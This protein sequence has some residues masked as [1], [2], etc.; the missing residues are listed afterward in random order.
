MPVLLAIGTGKG[1]FLARSEDERKSWEVSGPHFPMT[2]VYAVAIDKRRSVPRL[3]AGVT[4]PHFGPSVATSDD[5]G[6]SWREPERAPLAFPDDTGAALERV[7]Q[8][9]PGPASQPD[10]VYAGVEPSA[11]FVSDDGGCTYELV[12]GLWDHPHREH[13]A[14]GG[15]GQAIHTVLPHPTDTA[16]MLVA[17]STGGVYQSG[18][19]GATWAATNTGIG[20]PFLPDPLP[21]FGQCVHK[22]ARDAA[23]PTVCTPRTT[24]ASTAPTTAA[25]PGGRSRTGCRA[26]S[27][28]PWWRTRTGAT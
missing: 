13:W 11:L 14:P 16:A 25:R 24:P 2:G 7:W 18:D 17:M 15:G 27:G 8:L 4:S 6:A 26:T 5:L 21:E 10:R 19:N 9:A 1:L 22:V 28:S 12:R 3:L 20:A 23:I